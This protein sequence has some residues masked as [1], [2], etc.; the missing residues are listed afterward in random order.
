MGTQ[1]TKYG[2]N[3]SHY[4]A[5]I[6]LLTCQRDRLITPKEDSDVTPAT[7][8]PSVIQDKLELQA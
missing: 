5:H 3:G 8:C 6:N 1:V 7:Q 4:S 2:G